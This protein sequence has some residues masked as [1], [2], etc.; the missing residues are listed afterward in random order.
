MTIIE[1]ILICLG[2]SL[3]NFTVSASSACKKTEKVSFNTALKVAGIF[4]L[5]GVICLLCGFWGGVKLQKIIGAFDH[6]IAALI[7]AY[8]GI[9]MMIDTFKT[10]N[11]VNCLLTSIKPL[12][13][14]AL[15]TNIDVLAV[16]VSLAFYFTNIWL[17][18]IILSVCIMIATLVGFLVG[19]KI[20]QKLGHWAEFLGGAVLFLISI[21]IIVQG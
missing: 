14:M 4:T 7:L 16:G 9:K 19:I 17:V 3:D 21:K 2:L 13:L 11:E 12:I 8:I 20:G 6:W 10:Q 1:I 18:L 15:A 5:T